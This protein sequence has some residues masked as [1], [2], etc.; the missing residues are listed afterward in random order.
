MDALQLYLSSD[1]D[2]EASTVAVGKRKRGR[3][4]Q[5]HLS[6]MG[7]QEECSRQQE[8]RSAENCRSAS[9]PR[10]PS[11]PKDLLKGNDQSLQTH[12]LRVRSFPHIDGNFALHVYIPVVLSSIARSKLAPILKKASNLVPQ[13]Q[14]LENDVPFNP[15]HKSGN[16]CSSVDCIKLAKEY[17]ISLSRTVPIRIYQIDSIVS[18]LRHKFYNQKRYS[19]EF[20]KWAVF[21]NDERTRS[22]LA[23]EIVNGGFPEIQRQVCLVNDVYKLHDLPL[24]YKNARP[25]ISV[26]WALGNGDG[27]RKVAEELNKFSGV[28]ENGLTV[29]CSFTFNKVLCKIGQ[30]VY[31]IWTR[32]TQ[33][34]IAKSS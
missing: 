5:P 20:G 17:H 28:T 4:P 15:A 13:L 11:P 21:V 1:S 26:A 27:M 34:G 16:E 23:L 8:E 10:L 22:F 25:H 19:I 6:D 32:V 12:G 18:M 24:Y 33:H 30:Q 29:L 2:S 9:P 14:S 31:P 3:S 7:L